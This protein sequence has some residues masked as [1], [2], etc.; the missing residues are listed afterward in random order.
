MHEFLCTSCDHYCLCYSIINYY[1]IERRSYCVDQAGLKIT[2]HLPQLPEC[3]EY[4]CVLL[5]SDAVVFLWLRTS[6]ALYLL[7][8]L[9]WYFEHMS[10][11][12]SMLVDKLPNPHGLASKVF[13]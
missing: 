10:Y 6:C 3:W 4:R 1:F 8:C 11:L 9:L 13:R 7:P 12:I 5:R 2:I